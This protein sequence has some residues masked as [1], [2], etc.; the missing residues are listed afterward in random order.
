MS[1]ERSKSNKKIG[2]LDE[3]AKTQDTEALNA[4]SK[5]E[6]E[7]LIKEMDQRLV[8]GGQAL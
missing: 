3:E 5:E 8:M 7:R 4:P 1:I 2:K 6:L